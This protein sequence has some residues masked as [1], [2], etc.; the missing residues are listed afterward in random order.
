MIRAMSNEATQPEVDTSNVPNPDALKAAEEAA[1]AALADATVKATRA[2]AAESEIAQQVMM[3]HLN[4]R[5]IQLRVEV[6]E[7]KE[8]E[9]E[10]GAKVVELEA[11]IVELERDLRAA[12]RAV[13]ESV[14]IARELNG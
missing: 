8:R 13:D 5:V 2:A 4:Q 1:A 14:E 6:D 10:L 9:A 11:K 7:G 3:Q 12:D